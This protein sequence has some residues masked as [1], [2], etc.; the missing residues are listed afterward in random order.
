ML[1]LSGLIAVPF[2]LTARHADRW[3]TAIGA[4]TG[5]VSLALG[6]WLV[7]TVGA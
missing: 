5:S 6:I 1:A 2:V 3:H 4:T 7:W